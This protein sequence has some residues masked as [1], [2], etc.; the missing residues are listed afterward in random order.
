VPSRSMLQQ[1][2]HHEITQCGDLAH[3]GVLSSCGSHSRSH[4]RS[5]YAG[6]GAP[7]GAN[8]TAERRA[9]SED[10]APSQKRLRTFSAQFQDFRPVRAQIRPRNRMCLAGITQIERNCHDNCIQNFCR[11][12]PEDFVHRAG[13]HLNIY[14]VAPGAPELANRSTRYAE[15]EAKRLSSHRGSSVGPG[16]GR[17]RTY[18][19][20]LEPTGWSLRLGG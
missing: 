4:P 5:R 20:A 1:Q 14:D 15:R 17:Q 18:T 19:S 9:K 8:E 2:C 16:G 12:S 6:F 10:R 3:P 7:L 11:I 13:R